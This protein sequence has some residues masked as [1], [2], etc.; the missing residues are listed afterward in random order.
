MICMNHVNDNY[1]TE[2]YLFVLHETIGIRLNPIEKKSFIHTNKKKKKK[3][4]F[5][6]C[7]HKG[8]SLL[9]LIQVQCCKLYVSVLNQLQNDSCLIYL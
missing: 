3:I 1:T 9:Y 2:R 6:L 5:N 4:S 8:Q 7:L